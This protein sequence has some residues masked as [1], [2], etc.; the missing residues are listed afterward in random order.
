MLVLVLESSTSSAKALLYDTDKGV[1][2]TRDASYEDNGLIREEGVTDT[3]GVF[4]LTAGLARELAA[5]RDVAAVALCGTFHSM[6]VC[7]GDMEPLGSTYSWNYMAPSAHCADARAD[8][9]LADKLYNSTGCMPHVTYMRQTMR[10]LGENGLDLN[11][12]LLVSQGAYNFYRLTGE[13]RESV[14]TASGS[15]LLNTHTLGYDDFALDYAGIKKALQPHKPQEILKMA[16]AWRPWRSYAVVNL[17]NA[18]WEA[19]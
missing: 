10:Y 13:F 9:A 8:A 11:G 6:A 1:L 12:K 17:W 18:E 7:G 5:G 15:G 2:G 19:R 3:D 16:E 14:S 4:R